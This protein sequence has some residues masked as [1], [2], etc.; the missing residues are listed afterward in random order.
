MQKKIG[1]LLEEKVLK[2][3]K[4]KALEEH[5]TLNHIFEKALS[6]YLLRQSSSKQK[7]STVEMSFGAMRLS[8]KIVQKIAQEEIYE[9]E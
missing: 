7:L 8:S 1:T 3:A 2:E 6:D 5:T 9:T 4:Q